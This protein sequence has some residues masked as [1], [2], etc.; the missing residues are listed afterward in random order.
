[1]ILSIHLSLEN[2]TLI[3]QIIVGQVIKDYLKQ[4]KTTELLTNDNKKSLKG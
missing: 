1:M 2:Y 4:C 3:S